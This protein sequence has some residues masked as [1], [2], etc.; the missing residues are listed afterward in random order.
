LTSNFTDPHASAR[1][2]VEASV[3]FLFMSWH[4]KRAR[5]NEEKTALP[6]D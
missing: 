2:I 1:L 6:V 5:M 3:V 4:G